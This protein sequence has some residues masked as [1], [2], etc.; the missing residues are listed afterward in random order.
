MKNPGKKIN[1]K[2]IVVYDNSEP[3][4]NLKIQA[5]L[6]GF[7]FVNF[8]KLKDYRRDV[9]FSLQADF[10]P[11]SEAYWLLSEVIRNNLQKDDN[12]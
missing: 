4:G 1:K 7:E 6:A 10:H 3:S 8:Q 5:N 9:N 2:I 12:N 11:S